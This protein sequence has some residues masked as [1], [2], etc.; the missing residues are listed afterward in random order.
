M[1]KTVK[2]SLLSI[3]LAVILVLISVTSASAFSFNPVSFLKKTSDQLTQR[4][5]DIIYYLI[6]QK[7]YVFDGF[8]DPNNYLAIKIPDSADQVLIPNSTTSSVAKE[9]R[10][11]GLVTGNITQ[12]SVSTPTPISTIKPEVGS[13]VT[14]KPV[15]NYTNDSQ[16]LYFTNQER[17]KVAL[18]SL[19]ASPI[20]DRIASL[21][22]DDLFANQY[23]EHTSPTNGQTATDLAAKVGYNYLLI[24]E[25]LALGDFTNEQDIVSAWMQSSSHREN[26]LNSKYS[27]LGVAVKTDIF[28]GE[29]TTIAVQI[30]GT[31][32]SS[33]SIPNQ[34]TRSLIDSSTASIKKM[35]AEAAVLY[36]NLNDIKNDPLI[37]RSYYSQKVSEY[38]YFAKKI[39]DSVIALKNLTDIYNVQVNKYNTCINAR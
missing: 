36:N 10:Q 1:N 12:G 21:R 39:N 38:N 29:E 32:M 30:F 14:V 24:G 7:R 31:P 16:I 20:L 26:I 13:V 22:A 28:N 37:D 4:V 3:S 23:F 25:N 5:S 6:M 27:E 2:Y 11:T 34:S 9:T 33:C 19:M 18:S 17:E 15:S 35:Q 8:V